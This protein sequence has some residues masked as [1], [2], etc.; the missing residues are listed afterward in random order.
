MPTDREHEIA[1]GCALILRQGRREALREVL[2]EMDGR[3]ADYDESNLP[4]TGHYR[5]ALVSLRGWIEARLNEV[6]P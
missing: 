6:K 3:I 2:K 4:N 5:V 1:R